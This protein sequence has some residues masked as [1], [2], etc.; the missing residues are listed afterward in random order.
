[1]TPAA[2]A[3]QTGFDVAAIRA[4][5]PILL[6]QVHGR[7]LVYLD[8]AATTQ[9]PQCV[10]DRLMRYYRL[11]NANI[12]RGVHVLSVEATDAY[13]EARERVRRFINAAHAR[14]IVF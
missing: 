7:R 5:F 4:D 2:T 3:P 1:M 11:E 14:E 9:K 6:R 12:H 10:L 8:N 13:E